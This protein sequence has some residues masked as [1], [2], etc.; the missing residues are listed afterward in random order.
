ML[1][2]FSGHIYTSYVAVGNVNDVIIVL[3]QF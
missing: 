3:I 2:C 1:K